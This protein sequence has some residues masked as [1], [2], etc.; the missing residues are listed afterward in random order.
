M[1][2]L[3]V[4]AVLLTLVGAFQTSA[5]ERYSTPKMG[6][7]ERKAVL[8]AARIPVEK[9]LGQEI[10][11]QVTTLRVT[12]EWAFVHG[13]P[14]RPDGKPIDYSKS[15]YAQDVKDGTFGGEAAV[16]LAR[17]GAGWRLVTYSVGFGDVVWDSWDEEFGAP[18]WLWP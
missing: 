11:F 13:T 17:E 15:I 3:G 16:L 6:S 9:D 14:K 8:D 1:G 18:A 4:L 7:A 10:V 12:P 2:R 5:Q